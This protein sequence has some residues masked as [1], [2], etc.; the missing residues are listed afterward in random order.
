MKK[1]TCLNFGKG[2]GGHD[3]PEDEKHRVPPLKH[4]KH[5]YDMNGQLNHKV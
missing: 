4:N 5:L 1:K 3:E 2:H